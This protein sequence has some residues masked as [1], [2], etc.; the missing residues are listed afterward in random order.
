MYGRY[1]LNISCYLKLIEKVLNFR[2]AVCG[3]GVVVDPL[4][5][6]VLVVDPVRSVFCHLELLQQRNE[7]LLD[8]TLTGS[9]AEN[10][11]VKFRIK[12]VIIR[13]RRC[14]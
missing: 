8:V 3:H 4:V 10:T 1:V 14:R 9:L 11:I 13:R 12:Y 2:R 5:D 7:L 6:E